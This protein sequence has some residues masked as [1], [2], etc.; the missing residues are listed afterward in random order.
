MHV[1]KISPNPGR[2]FDSGLYAGEVLEQHSVQ[3]G[4]GHVFLPY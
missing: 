2:S 1:P 3:V 4:R